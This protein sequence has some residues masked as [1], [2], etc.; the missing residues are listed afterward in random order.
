MDDHLE[1]FCHSIMLH[2]QNSSKSG[3]LFVER[4]EARGFTNSIAAKDVKNTLMQ[5]ENAQCQLM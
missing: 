1:K 4:V 2:S 5:V 3:A